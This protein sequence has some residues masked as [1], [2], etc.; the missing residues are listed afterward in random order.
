MPEVTKPFALGFMGTTTNEVLFHAAEEVVGN[1]IYMPFTGSGKDISWLSRAGR[2]IVSA[3]TQ[4]LSLLMVDGIFNATDLEGSVIQEGQALP[5]DEGYAT[6]NVP[7]KRMTPLS[8]AII[9]G[10]A[11]H[12]TLFDKAVLCKCIIQSTIGGRLTHWDIADDKFVD[13]FHRAKLAMS[14]YINLPGTR[15]HYHASYID[16]QA[17]WDGPESI[18]TIWID[19]PKVVDTQDVYSRMFVKLNSCLAQE[20]VE[21]P[22]WKYPMMIP[23]LKK[24]WEL[25]CKRIIQF[26]CSDVRPTDDEVRKALEQYGNVQPRVRMLHGSK[27]DY[28]HILDKE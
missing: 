23:N 18:D 14:E 10:V 15:L 28:I 20:Q 2:T 17:N 16:L 13:K 9:D 24:I 5:T 8:L 27:A 1:N 12:G 6:E 4:Y 19:P 26:Y 3:D 21:L 7:F 22:K 25:P 11:M